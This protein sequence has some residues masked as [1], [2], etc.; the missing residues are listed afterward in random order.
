MTQPMLARPDYM[1]LSRPSLKASYF[2][3]HSAPFHDKLQTSNYPHMLFLGLFSCY[4]ILMCQLFISLGFYDI[5]RH[6]DTN[7]EDLRFLIVGVND[8]DYGIFRINHSSER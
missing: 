3:C 2:L 5:A 4:L 1:F 7:Q 6:V 8:N